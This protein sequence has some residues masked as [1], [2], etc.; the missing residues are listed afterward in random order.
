MEI[1]YKQRLKSEEGPQ[2]KALQT[3]AV[4]ATLGGTLA[5]PSE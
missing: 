4:G 1:P 5:V 3:N 2:E